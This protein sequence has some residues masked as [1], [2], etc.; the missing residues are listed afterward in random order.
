MSAPPTSVDAHLA[1]LEEL[2]R[3]VLDEA[4]LEQLLGQVL[5]ATVRALHTPAAA[6]VITTEG[7]RHETVAGTDA[8]AAV[9]AC[10]HELGEGPGIDALLSGEE[11]LVADL[12]GDDRWPALSARATA[13]GLRSV[14]AVP[15]VVGR[16]RVGALCVFGTEVGG[17][18]E[19]DRA[20]VRGIAGPLA[21]TLANGRAYRRVAR[22]TEQLQQALA[23]RAAIERAKGIVMVTQ[24]A[25]EEA[26]FEHLRRTSQRTNRKLR[27]VARGVLASVEGRGPPPG[28]V[29]ARERST[30]E[31]G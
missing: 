22:L 1:I 17:L 5:E 23:S 12:E 9:A 30:R 20:F 27:D 4:P 26:A 28:A 18:G 13:L 14:Q 2:T 29:D 16:T 6:V 7:G 21:T 8:A 11:T 19:E 3:V 31:R 10:Q 24:G 15:L 25:D